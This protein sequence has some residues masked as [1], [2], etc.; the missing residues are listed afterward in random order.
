MGDK[1]LTL[2]K[3]HDKSRIGYKGSH[4]NKTHKHRIFFT[5]FPNIALFSGIS[6]KGPQR[7]TNKKGPKSIWVIKIE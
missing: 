1:C 3:S 4:K 5:K 6:R 2:R 7:S